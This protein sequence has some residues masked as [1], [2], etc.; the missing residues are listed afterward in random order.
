MN[1]ESPNLL[2]KLHYRL[3]ALVE[4]RLI[5]PARCWYLR[6]RGARIGK[7]NRIGTIHVSW[8]HR[9]QLGD[10]CVVENGVRFHYYGRSSEGPGICIGDGVFIGAGC[11]FNISTSVEIGDDCLLAPGCRIT[12]GPHEIAMAASS[13]AQQ[14]VRG[15]PITIGPDVRLGTNAIVLKGVTIGR[16][17]IIGPGTVVNRSVPPRE[18]WS[19][20]P[21][22]K[23]GGQP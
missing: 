7:R 17:A 4:D 8:P 23:V 19:G 6:S 9:L 5:M 14:L 3:F 10:N 18:I 13:T 11:D 22:R 16:G 1:A 21:A 15:E 20:V 12:D 2:S